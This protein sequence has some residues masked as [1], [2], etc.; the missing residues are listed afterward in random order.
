[1]VEGINAGAALAYAETEV[2]GEG[3]GNVRLETDHYQALLYGDYTRGDFYLEGNVSVGRNR[4]KTSR[5][6]SSVGAG[7][8]Q[9]SFDGWQY[10]AT[11]QMGWPRVWRENTY[12]TPLGGVSWTQVESGSYTETGASSGG[13]NLTVIP[14]DVTV[15][16]GTLGARLHNEYT[17]SGGG[18]IIPS[19]EVGVNYDF[20]GDEATATAQYTGGGSGVYH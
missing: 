11:V 10:N 12:F 1:M 20:A 16:V 8:A 9:G 4:S 5:T 7:T 15:L 18:Q 3:A 17:P 14:D 2:D 19:L 13:L 6:L